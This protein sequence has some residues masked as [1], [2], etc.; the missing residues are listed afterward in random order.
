MALSAFLNE[1]VMN[2]NHPALF[3]I[4]K[5]KDVLFMG[6]LAKP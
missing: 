5:K 6:K 2:V 4:R 1:L 3:V